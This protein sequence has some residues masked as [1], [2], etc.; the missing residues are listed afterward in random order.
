MPET[1]TPVS[2]DD[3]PI[4]LSASGVTLVGDDNGTTKQVP[5]SLL[6]DAITVDAEDVTYSGTV[7]GVTVSNVKD[8]LDYVPSG[9]DAIPS[10]DASP[11]L[12]GISSKWS[13]SDHV[14]PSD[15]T[16][17]S[18]SRRINNIQLTSDLVLFWGMTLT[19][20]L[21]WSG[22]G[23]Y[24]NTSMTI[25]VPLWAGLT[26][27]SKISL[28]PTAAQIAQLQADGVTALTVENNNGTL[29]AYA[30]GAAP[31]TAMTIDCTV[32]EVET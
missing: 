13:R 21:S 16:K 10:A 31:T 4:A 20:P 30:L 7:G 1:P 28:Q 27:K 11:G 14:H 12:S 18:T 2:I 6:A 15:S 3:L 24:T 8:A 26:A 5:V 17:V 29:T 25:S 23:P 32:M 9:S 19:F 22:T